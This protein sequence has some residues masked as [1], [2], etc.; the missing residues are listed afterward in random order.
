MTPTAYETPVL[1]RPTFDPTGAGVTEL[2]LDDP[3]WLA[4]VSDH[5]DAGPFHI[6]EWT[7]LLADCYGFRPFVLAVTGSD[8]ELIGGLPVVEVRT[9]LGK[10]RWVSLPFTDSCEP[11]FAEATG[12]ARWLPQLRAHAL[13]AGAEELEMRCGLAATEGVFPVEVGYTY[14][15]RL[16]EGSCDLHPSKGHRQH[17]N[18]ALRSGVEVVRGAAPADVDRYYH[19]H[20]LTRRRQGVPVQPRRFFDL[21]WSR[22]LAR[23]H[24]FV[25]TAMDGD[26]PLAAVLFLLHNRQLVAKYRASDPAQRDGGAG[27]LVDWDVMASCC[28]DGEMI[29]DLGRTDP[30]EEGQRRYKTGWGAVESPLVYTHLADRRPAPSLLHGGELARKVIR[31]SPLWV[32][33]AV[34]E[35][36]YRWTA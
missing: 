4:M 19:L 20:S 31:R 1:H 6:P 9:P 25:A 24:G 8:A 32:S 12:L 30:G 5:P 22:M 3:R 36:L 11:L 18:H 35:A 26:R 34:G 33:R 14:R 21:V 29:L 16:P 28:G 17:R 23:G 10:R 13:A 7:R 15:L 27:F 2:A